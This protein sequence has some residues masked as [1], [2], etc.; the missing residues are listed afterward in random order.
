MIA[1]RKESNTYR[2]QALEIVKK[3]LREEPYLSITGLNEK[4]GYS[5]PFLA[6]MYYSVRK[7]NEWKT[8]CVKYEEDDKSEKS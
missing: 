2:E 8:W 3:A 1:G 5:K 7:S 4:T 6:C